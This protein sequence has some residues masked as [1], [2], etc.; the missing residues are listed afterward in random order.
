[1]GSTWPKFFPHFHRLSFHLTRSFS[2]FFFILFSV[3]NWESRRETEHERERGGD[4]ETEMEQRESEEYGVEQR[5]NVCSIES[6]G[7]GLWER[8]KVLVGAK[9]T[10]EELNFRGLQRLSFAPRRIDPMKYFLVFDELGVRLAAQ[11]NFLHIRD[12]LGG[13]GQFR[14]NSAEIS[15]RDICAEEMYPCPA[16]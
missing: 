9:K 13:L 10:E 12:Q 4:Y 5:K 1:M 3:L 7:W 15:G 11:E 8:R 2:I 16:N 14:K 6:S